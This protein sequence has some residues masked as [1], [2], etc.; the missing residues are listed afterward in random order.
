MKF[1]ILIIEDEVAISSVIKSIF[2]LEGHQILVAASKDEGMNVYRQFKPDVLLLDLCL[3]DCE[4]GFEVLKK[5]RIE[6]PSLFVIILSS[7]VQKEQKEQAYLLGAD[8]YLS[9]NVVSVDELYSSVI[10]A[11]D[12]IKIKRTLHLVKSKDLYIDFEKIKLSKNGMEIELPIH[13]YEILELLA[14]NA[15]KFLSKDFIIKKIW[16][17]KAFGNY[18]SLK[19]EIRKL[20]LKIEDN[21]DVPMFITTK[22]DYGYRFNIL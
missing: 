22:H 7:M 10:T 2:E 8:Y 12:N 11:I 3:P 17:D 19:V 20:R 18:E 15:G 5:L 21:P 16:K 6:S 1:S 9:K 13:Q 4:D 14:R